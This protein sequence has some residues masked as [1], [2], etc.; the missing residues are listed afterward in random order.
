MVSRVGSLPTAVFGM[1]P[2]P[3]ALAALLVWL[4]YG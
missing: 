1:A 2:L 4:R 3:L